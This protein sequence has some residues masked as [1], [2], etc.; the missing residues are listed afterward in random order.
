[1]ILL[2]D[3]FITNKVSQSMV[4]TIAQ[5][6]ADAIFEDVIIFTAED[7]L[8]FKCVPNNYQVQGGTLQDA[9]LGY[10]KLHEKIRNRTSKIELFWTENN[11]VKKSIRIFARAQEGINE[12]EIARILGI[13]N[14]RLIGVPKIDVMSVYKELV[15]QYPEKIMKNWNFPSWNV[16]K[17]EY[18]WIYYGGVTRGQQNVNPK[19]TS[20]EVTKV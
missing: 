10:F 1:M 12:N 14:D 15:Y 7:E 2:N 6:T 13:L 17:N 16:D 5:S 8:Q 3:N 4:A 11:D 20:D 18:N 19:M 9:F